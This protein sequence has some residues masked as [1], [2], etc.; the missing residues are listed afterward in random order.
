MCL[1]CRLKCVSSVVV[2]VLFS[3]V[4]CSMVLILGVW[5]G[6]VGCMMV[7]YLVVCCVVDDGVVCGLGCVGFV[8]G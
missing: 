4:R 1:S 8:I 3:F 2:G 7:S 6:V 5:M